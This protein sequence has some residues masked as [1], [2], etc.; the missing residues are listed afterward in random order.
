MP[1]SISSTTKSSSERDEAEARA[2]AE[3][4]AWGR[5]SR[6]GTLPG[7]GPWASG[8]AEYVPSWEP[9][10]KTGQGHEHERDDHAEDEAADVRKEGD[11]AAVRGRPEES[12]VGLDELVQEPGAEEEP[13]R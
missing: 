2:E 13:G 9:S 4:L 10:G 12:E 5:A 1:F 8:A 11:A 6:G 7:P 3:D